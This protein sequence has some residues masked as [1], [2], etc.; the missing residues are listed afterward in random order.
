MGADKETEARVGKDFA[1]RREAGI[2]I[3]PRPPQHG[4]PLPWSPTYGDIPWH[5]LPWQY[6][7]GEGSQCPRLTL[8]FSVTPEVPLIFSLMFSPV[9]ARLLRHSSTMGRTGAGEGGRE[10]T[11]A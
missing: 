3:R 4:F 7:N 6:L 10:A 5:S 9:Q 11:V 1:P 2:H 8:A